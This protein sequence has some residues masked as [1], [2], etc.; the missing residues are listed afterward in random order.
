MYVN[1]L[2]LIHPNRNIYFFSSP[3]FFF[4]LNNNE[5]K[6]TK[7]T[8]F[9]PFFFL[10]QLTD[11]KVVYLES[12]CFYLQISTVISHDILSIESPFFFSFFLIIF[13][14]K[15]D[16]PFENY[17]LR[18]RSLIFFNFYLLREICFTPNSI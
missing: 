6:N 18:N 8:D 16:I 1:E 7:L 5:K 9:Y 3:F 14:R 4:S 2:L 15:S 17:S 13:T 11:I 12:G 10:I